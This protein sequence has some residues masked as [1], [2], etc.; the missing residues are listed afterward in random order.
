[1]N[2]DSS[3]WGDQAEAARKRF[4]SRVDYENYIAQLRETPRYFAEQIANMRAGLARGF[5]PPKSTLVG[6]DSTIASVA[7][8]ASPEATIYDEPF[9]Q[10][11]ASIPPADQAR[12]RA[13]ASRTIADAVM[14]AYRSLLVFFRQ[15]YAPH[16]HEPLAAEAL[17][18]G[19]AYYRAKIKE[20]TTLDMPPA[21]IHELGL[22]EMAKIHAEMLQTMRESGF[23]GDLPAFLNYLKTD[24]GFYAKSPDEL[25]KDAAWI[26]KSF[27]GVSERYF[28]HAPRKRFAI[29]PVPADEAPFYTS[30]RGRSR[31]LPGQHLRPSLTRAL[32]LAGADA[33]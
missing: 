31:C 8:A 11:P 17:P 10:M 27:D 4:K 22:R 12:L 23:S 14:P 15:E 25:L 24:P 13:E 6:R 3:F 21:E 2:A 1:M 18:D 26:A 7:D 16:A 5:T 33:A 29:K 20:F 28:G 19:K 9:R 30:G 32:R